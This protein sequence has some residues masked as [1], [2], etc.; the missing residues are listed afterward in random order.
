MAEDQDSDLG[1]LIYLSD[2]LPTSLSASEWVQSDY[3]TWYRIDGLSTTYGKALTYS[4]A[5][6][7]AV[8]SQDVLDAFPVFTSDFTLL[9]ISFLLNYNC[10]VS[11]A[12]SKDGVEVYSVS[13]PLVTEVSGYTMT[14]GL[15][16]AA[17]FSLGPGADID[18]ADV[19]GEYEISMTYD[20]IFP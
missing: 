11:L 7:T 9:Q 13:G 6:A 8:A 16:V 12:I 14:N 20:G 10:N 1:D 18:V 15:G 4:A 3:G 19:R 17:L 2:S 5:S